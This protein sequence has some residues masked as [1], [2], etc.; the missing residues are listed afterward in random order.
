MNILFAA[1][2]LCLLFS[3]VYANNEGQEVKDT[4]NRFDRSL[5]IDAWAEYGNLINDLAQ[6]SPVVC[7][8]PANASGLLAGAT[9]LVYT[10][11]SK[12]YAKYFRT[13]GLAPLEFAVGGKDN[14]ANPP[15]NIT[16]T[17]VLLQQLI[18]FYQLIYTYIFSQ[19]NHYLYSAPQIT[20]T[21]NNPEF[22]GADTALLVAENESRGFVCNADPTVFPGGRAF[23][24]YFNVFKHVFCYED[25][26]GNSNDGWKLCGFFEANKGIFLQ[27]ASAFVQYYPVA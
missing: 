9:K 6:Y 5:V 24:V 21:K 10:T 11:F 16:S 12:K 3:A 7:G 25:N 23:Q 22:N 20:F 19:P 26:Q 4:G 27:P 8:Q 17:A 18:P 2:A 15:V 13:S 1:L 14:I